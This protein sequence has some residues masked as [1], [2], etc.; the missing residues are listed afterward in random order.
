FRAG[1]RVS[2]V[3]A[4]C[5]P[6]LLGEFRGER[7][8]EIVLLLDNTQSMTQ[9]ARRLSAPDQFRVALAQGKAEPG[10][11][12][13]EGS[14]ALPAGTLKDPP[15]ERLVREI[16]NNPKLR[17]LEGLQQH[18]PVVPLL[19]GNDARTALADPSPVAR[20][21]VTA[22]QILARYDA[23]QSQTA[24]ADALHGLLQRKD[25]DLPAAVVVMTDGRDNA[26]K[27]ALEEV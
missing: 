9:Q 11:A 1:R 25:G 8:R 22:G 10:T 5:R 13:P 27:Y 26:S 16:L 20:R 4:V 15:R 21:S 19:L 17:L 23:G 14:A 2:R 12:L 7:P 24:L 6:V 3:A 18:G